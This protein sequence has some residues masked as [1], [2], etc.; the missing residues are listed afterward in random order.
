MRILALAVITLAAIVPGRVSGQPSAA[1]AFEVASV[2][3]EPPEG[4]KGGIGLFTYPGGRVTA[5][6]PLDYLIQQAFD[7]QRFQ[8]AGGPH[9]I[10]EDR[11]AIDAKPPASSKSS[12]S[13]PNNPK[14]PPN[15]EQRQML[16]ALLVERFHLKYRLETKEGPVYLLT[17]TNKELKLQDPKDKDA[18]PWVGNPGGGAVGGDGIAGINA[19][20]TLLAARLGPYLGR[21]VIDQTGIEG[22]FDFKYAYHP[23]DSEPDLISTILVSVQGLGLKLETGRGP[24]QTLVI[25]GVE[26]P[27]SN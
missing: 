5:D 20:M 24:V 12:K 11:F 14:L 25:E 2:K 15:Q 27:A 19:S 10:H 7:I 8:I 17:K 6:A 4:V 22:A 18:Y 3:A 16:Q 13:N 21:P 23:V 1:P 9:W 26:K